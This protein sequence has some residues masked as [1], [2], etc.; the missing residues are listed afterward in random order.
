MAK[1][2][3]DP[4][5]IAHRLTLMVY[6]AWWFI[7]EVFDDSRLVWGGFC[8]KVSSGYPTKTWHRYWF[9]QAIKKKKMLATPLN[10]V[11]R[12]HQQFILT[13]LRKL[14]WS[15][16]R[17]RPRAQLQFNLRNNVKM[18]CWC[19]RFTSFN[20][21]ASIFFFLIAWENQYLCQ[22]FVGY[23]DDTLIQKPPQ[24]RR[25]SSN[26]SCINHHAI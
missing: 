6:I 20:G 14:N 13:L 12:A 7:Q 26:T 4:K 11:K 23:P 9:S 24:T 10:D 15:W 22:V 19:A 16:A 18:N 2:Y 8:I 25:L 17:G 5:W 21:V 3:E 1:H